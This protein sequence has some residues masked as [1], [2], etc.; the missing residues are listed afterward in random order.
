MAVN[1]NVVSVVDADRLVG[2]TGVVRPPH[3]DQWEGEYVV[4]GYKTDEKD[5]SKAES[6]SL[7]STTI[8]PEIIRKHPRTGAVVKHI[9][10]RPKFVAPTV[11]PR[12]FLPAV[13]PA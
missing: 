4:T 9:R 13:A 12:W 2:K 10:P 11:P 1:S 3:K 8:L 6:I 5:P 7:E